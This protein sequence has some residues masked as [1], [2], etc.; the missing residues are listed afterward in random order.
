M[1]IFVIMIQFNEYIETKYRE[2]IWKT[3]IIKGTIISVYDIL[4]WLK[5]ST[6]HSRIPCGI[7]DRLQNYNIN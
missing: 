2:E 5:T 7:Q 4:S 3:T 6:A 1:I